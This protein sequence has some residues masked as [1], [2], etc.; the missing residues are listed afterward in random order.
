MTTVDYFLRTPTGRTFSL[1]WV[2][3]LVSTLGSS[4]TRFGLAIWI[5]TETGS[6]MQLSLL[7]L[8]ATLPG[9]LMSPFAGSLIDRWDRRIAMIV[10]DAG[11]AMGTLAIGLLLIAGGL[12]MWHLYAALAFSSVFGSFQF[13]AYSAATTML[14][15]KDQYGRAAGMV[16]L[17]GSIGRVASPAV[18]GI[19]VVTSGLT[20]LFVIDFI[21]FAVAVGTLAFVRFPNPEKSSTEPVTV[22]GLLREAKEGLA[23]VTQRRALLILLLTFS[24]VNFAF[25]FQSVLLVPLLLSLTSEATAGFV[26]SISMVGLVAGSLLM[27]TWGGTSRRIRDLYVAIGITGAGLILTGLR[28]SVLLVLVAITVTHVALPV[29]GGSSQALWQAKVPPSLQGRVFAVRQ[30]FAFAAIPASLLIAGF[31][32]GSVLEPLFADDGSLS[33]S[34]G[35]VFG[36]G[37]GR[38]IAFLLSTMGLAVVAITFVSWRS[39][40]IT[41]FDRDVPDIDTPEAEVAADDAVPARV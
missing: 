38:G 22:A 21:T 17:A 31:L 25:S 6:T 2:G 20:A 26:V 27:S 14:V 35:Q 18:A 16:Q 40:A 19:I 32:A 24:A 29:A 12:E 37:E 28:P 33:G 30:M 41:H 1:V 23:F 8:A 7:I 36:T 11:A 10:S 9:V 4:M 13:P 3:Q 15:P 39:P 5:F 34:L